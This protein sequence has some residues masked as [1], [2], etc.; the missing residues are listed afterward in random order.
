MKRFTAGA[1]GLFAASALAVLGT[2][3]TVQE[4]GI[5]ANEVV[6]ITSSNLGG[7]VYAG[8]VK[9]SVNGTL[10]DSFCID[11]WHWSSGNTSY[12]LIPLVNDSKP[13]E[14]IDAATAL[15][16]EQLW[17]LYYTPSISPQDAAGLQIAIW[18]LVAASAAKYLGGTATQASLFH[19]NGYD[20]GAS[21][22][23]NTLPTNTIPAD[24]AAV[25]SL[26]DGKVLD[27]Q[28]YV[29]PGVP[30][31]GATLVLLGSGLLALMGIRRRLSA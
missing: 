27:G 30:D 2:P 26:V 14:H 22:M 25:T 7:D 23:I 1:I 16:I 8:V 11:P 4:L 10:T 18:D 15:Q 9:L 31:G 21:E 20:W 17:T 19:V 13:P 29:V 3:V 5:G 28:D 12:D 6:N 24:L